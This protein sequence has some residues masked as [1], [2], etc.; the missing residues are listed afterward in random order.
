MAS[1]D[2]YQQM[3]R[4]PNP[5][6]ELWNSPAGPQKLWSPK[7][8]NTFSDCIA[9][10]LNA[11]LRRFDITALR[12]VEIRARTGDAQ[13]DYPD[14]HV[15]AFSAD[16]KKTLLAVIVEVKGCWHA[17]VVESITNQ[18]H[19]RYLRSA[20][21]GIHVTGYFSSQGWR[22]DDPRKT[23]GLSKFAYAEVVAMVA[24]ERA[25]LLATSSKR[26]EAVVLDTRM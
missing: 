5:T 23:S 4:G 9:R 20:R 16:G 24:A 21:C 11:D 6:T 3:L 22:D 10:H 1:L 17:E 2:R 12:E 8:E 7:D 13:G 14:I 25:K 19:D 26:V 18:L 15:Q